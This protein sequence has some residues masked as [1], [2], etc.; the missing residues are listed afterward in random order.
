VGFLIGAATLDLRRLGA[1]R[2]LAMPGLSATVGE[3]I[4]ALR[5]VA[6]DAA[7]RLIRHEPNPTIIR[8]VGGWARN[9][10]A[11]RAIELGFRADASFTDI[12]RAHIDDELG[13]S[14]GGRSI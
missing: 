12:V 1:R 14:I 13:G 7:V 2:N 9:I 6:G 11:K 8:M 5:A 4:E 3:E 10:E